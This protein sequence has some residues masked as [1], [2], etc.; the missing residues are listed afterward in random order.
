MKKFVTAAEILL[1]HLQA[2]FVCAVRDSKILSGRSFTKSIYLYYLLPD[3]A[4]KNF[5]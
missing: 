1:R 2:V 3:L 5:V 4:T